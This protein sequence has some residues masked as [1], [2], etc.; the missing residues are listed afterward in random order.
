MTFDKETLWRAIERLSRRQCVS[1]IVL[2][3]RAYCGGVWKCQGNIVSNKTVMKLLATYNIDIVE[4]IGLGQLG[5]DE[6]RLDWYEH[7]N[8]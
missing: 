3:R 6:G 8:K 4:F 7:I 2:L 1:V 5:N